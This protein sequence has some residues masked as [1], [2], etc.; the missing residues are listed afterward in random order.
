MLHLEDAIGPVKAGLLADLIAVEGDPTRDIGAL[1]KIRFV[2]KAGAVSTGTRERE[3]TA[4]GGLLVVCAPEDRGVRAARVLRGNRR[5]SGGMSAS[6]TRC[7]SV[8]KTRARPT[9]I[10]GGSPQSVSAAATDSS[11]ET[12]SRLGSARSLP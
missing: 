10:S 9:S 5:A 3:A 11:V 8:R 12:Y 7:T 6:R 1:R 4:M 2:M